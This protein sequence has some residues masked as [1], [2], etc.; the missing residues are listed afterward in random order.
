MR[1]PRDIADL[2]SCIAILAPLVLP[3]KMT[4]VSS[5]GNLLVYMGVDKLPVGNGRGY[6]DMNRIL[7]FTNC[8]ISKVS[9]YE[10]KYLNQKDVLIHEFEHA[11][12][13]SHASKPYSFMLTMSWPERPQS[14]SLLMK[15]INILI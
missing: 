12:G 2:D 13:L 15:W 6:T 7:F 4:R 14:S 11:I 9:I 10:V 1:S 5:D 3:L 8:S